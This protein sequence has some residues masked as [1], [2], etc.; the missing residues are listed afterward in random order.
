MHADKRRRLE[1]AK[2]R[3]RAGKT[4]VAGLLERNERKGKSQVRL[5]IVSDARK[6]VLQKNLRTHVETGSTVSTDGLLSYQGIDREYVHG[7][8]NHAERYANGAV[9]TNGMENFWSLLK[10]AIK[11]GLGSNNGVEN[12]QNRAIR[13]AGRANVP[14]IQ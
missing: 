11:G 14:R 6:A 12:A 4:I 8:I 2:G 1:M 5:R 7:V 13:D 3:S 9:H 10:R